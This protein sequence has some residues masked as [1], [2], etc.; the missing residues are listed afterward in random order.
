MGDR[1]KP[2]ADVGRNAASCRIEASGEKRAKPA[3]D[4]PLRPVA[5]APTFVPPTGKSAAKIAT[6]TRP[7]GIGMTFRGSVRVGGSS[8]QM[9]V[10]LL[11]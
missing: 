9:G 5:N 10:D 1:L 3:M 2:D 7:Y 4:R 11:T 6:D 8:T